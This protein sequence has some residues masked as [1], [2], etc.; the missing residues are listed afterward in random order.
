[1]YASMYIY[2]TYL[3]C[4]LQNMPLTSLECVLCGGHFHFVMEQ[5]SEL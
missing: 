3:I 5:M 1:M 2:E 4:R